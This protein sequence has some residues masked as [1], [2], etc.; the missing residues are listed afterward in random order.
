MKF[1]FSSSFTEEER[2]RL[3][4]LCNSVRQYSKARR[5]EGKLLVR[6]RRGNPVSGHYRNAFEHFYWVSEQPYVNRGYYHVISITVPRNWAL[7]G[8]LWLFAH[9]F[10]HYLQSARVKTRKYYERQAERFAM[11]VVKRLCDKGT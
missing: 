11:D 5:P 4:G 8:V 10:K 9:E 3:K 7:R 1:K 2:E 6:F